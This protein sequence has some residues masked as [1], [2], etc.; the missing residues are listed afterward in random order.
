MIPIRT[1]RKGYKDY[2]LTEGEVEKTIEFCKNHTSVDELIKIQQAAMKANNIIWQPLMISVCSS[3]SYE[4]L[5]KKR[6]DIIYGKNDFYGY[7][8]KFIAELYKLIM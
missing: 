4:V 2:G 6:N 1:R 5:M 8:R 7:R 3:Q